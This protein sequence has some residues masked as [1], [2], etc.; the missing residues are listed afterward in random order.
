MNLK[1]VKALTI[2]EFIQVIRDPRSLALAIFIP[3]L[4]LVL[5]GF[6]LTLDVDNIPLAVWDQDKSQ[7]SSDFLLDFKNSK[8]FKIVGY[9]DNYDQLQHL[10]DTNKALMAMVISHDFSKCIMS[11]Q[12]AQVQLIVDGSDSNTATIA[13]GYAQ[14]LVSRYNVRFI[15]QTFAKLGLKRPSSIDARP[16]V[17]FN[18]D[19]KSRNFIIPGLV[20]VIMM[21]ISALLT[22]LTV[23]REWERGTMEQLISTPITSGELILGKFLPYFLIGFLDL[24]I[25]VA[26]AQFIYNVP[27]RGNLLLLF[28][29]SGLFLTG[30]L[31]QGMFISISVK[32]QLLASQMAILSTFL[33]AFL[34][35]GFAYAISNMPKAIQLITYLVPARYFITIVRGIYL[36]GVGLKVLWFDC[37]FLLLFTS[38]M[39]ALAAKKFKKK[40]A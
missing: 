15:S 32:N 24:L 36:K 26:M 33:P 35:S 23:A 16:R 34:L 40:V 29:L 14:A 5:F 22:S 7:A 31:S 10:I 3:I 25:A 28:I 18:E 1:R 39:V 8:Y 12:P 19:L 27:L 11:G 37:L 6:A 20:V 9:L 30:A 38:C 17:W 21:I 2:K 4:L 13:T